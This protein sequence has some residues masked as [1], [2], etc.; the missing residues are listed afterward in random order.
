MT[1]NKYTLPIVASLIAFAAVLILVSTYSP[2]LVQGSTFAGDPQMSVATTSAA[3]SVTTST[4]VL[5]TTTNT[6]G[7]GYTRAYAVICNP[8]SN[9]VYINIDADKAANAAGSFTYVIAAA[10][11]YNACYEL[12]GNQMKNSGSITASSTNQTATTISVKE[13]VY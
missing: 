8:N 7:T 2:V 9:P 13:Y 3:F 4:R 6:G 5:G 11:G 1:T 12:T 10:A